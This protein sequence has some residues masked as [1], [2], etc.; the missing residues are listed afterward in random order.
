[1][2]PIAM[3]LAMPDLVKAADAPTPARTFPWLS[4]SEGANFFYFS[5][6]IFWSECMLSLCDFEP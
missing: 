1:M 3:S 6:S 5:F 2:Q 4:G